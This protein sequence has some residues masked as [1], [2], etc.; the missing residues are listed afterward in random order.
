MQRRGELFFGLPQYKEQDVVRGSH[1]LFLFLCT[2]RSF[3]GTK[4]LELVGLIGWPAR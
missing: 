3:E 1:L 2:D 4:N